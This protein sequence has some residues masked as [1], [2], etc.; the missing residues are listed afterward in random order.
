MGK[1]SQRKGKR[2]EEELE[3]ILT[4]YGY[5]VKRGQSQNHGTEPD[6]SG[7]P[8][9]HVE[10]KRNERLNIME[11]MEQAER[12]SVRFADGFPAVFHRRNRKPWVVSMLLTDWIEIY[13]KGVD[14]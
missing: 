11:A 6:L 4:E 5:A 14:K 8:G 13:R 2:G 10:V 3:T 1:A 7:L 9:I 12:D